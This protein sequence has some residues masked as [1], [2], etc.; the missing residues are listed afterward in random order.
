MAKIVTNTELAE[1][2]RDV[3]AAYKIADDQKNKF[4]IIAYERAADAVEHLSSEAKD[5]W[6][7]GKLTEV[8]GIG[9]AIASHLDEL[10][11][12]GK[13]KHFDQVLSSL[14]PAVFALMK[15]PGVGAKTAYKLS[16]ELGIKNAKTALSALKAAIAKGK[17]ASLE[18]FGKVREENIRKSIGQVKKGEKRLLLPYASQI[19]DDLIDWIKKSKDVVEV[20]PLG[21]LRRKASTVGDIDLAVATDRPAELLEH[22]VNYPKKVRKIEIGPESAA[23]VV[24]GN[25][26]GD[27]MATPSDRFGALLQHFTGSKHHNIAL[28][29]HA[30]KMGLSLNEK[31]ISYLKTKKIKKVRTEEEFYNTLSM[32]WMPP[33]LREDAGE[34]QASLVHRLPNLVDLA[35][36]KGDLQI[37][38][39]FDIETSHDLGLSSMLEVVKKADSLGYEYIA[40]TEHNPAQKGHKDSQIVDLLKR[41]KEVVDKLN[42][43]LP[44]NLKTFKKAF[45]SLE[46]DILPNGSLPVPVKGFDYLDFALCSIHSSFNQDKSKMTE[47]VITAFSYP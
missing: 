43:S 29:E 34:V 33:E 18:G 19:A 25:V 47:R 6:D 35:D 11:A 13:S 10:F 46:I 31:G 44:P 1:L 4:R 2:L 12:T 15:I 7:E 32:D 27:A 41:K 8:S 21:S 24:R 14:P 16:T 20:Y 28:R 30:L 5:L 17:V 26:Q 22:F 40:F 9:P 42:S 36:I 45:N 39:D 38:S 37:H 3:A 23:I